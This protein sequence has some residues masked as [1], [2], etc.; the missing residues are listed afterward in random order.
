MGGGGGAA[1][2][3][4]PEAFFVSSLSIFFATGGKCSPGGSCPSKAIGSAWSAVESVRAVNRVGAGTGATVEVSEAVKAGSGAPAG[5]L[6]W[7]VCL[8]IVKMQ[9]LTMPL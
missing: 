4:P 3:V 8:A 9:G 2:E 5:I 7:F 6:G 1:F